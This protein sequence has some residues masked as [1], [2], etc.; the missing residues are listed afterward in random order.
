MKKTIT[1]NFKVLSTPALV[2]VLLLILSIFALKTFADK[3]SSLSN[4]L[5]TLS[6]TETS[7]NQKLSSLQSVST[8]A[9]LSEAVS[10]ALPGQNSGLLVV[11]QIRKVSS[12][13]GLVLGSI[14]SGQELQGQGG[15]SHVDMSVDVDGQFNQLVAFVSLLNGS[16]PISRISR[17][18]L[19]VTG[20]VIHTT[21]DLS[22]YW[23]ALPTTLPD[24]SASVSDLKDDEKTLLTKLTSLKQPLFVTV[25]PT[26]PTGRANPFSL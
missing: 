10:A 1:A 5:S 4:E 21:V 3:V 2:F 25:Q 19:S 12:D 15:V 6:Q 24:I 22:S 17:M 8:T 18:K 13:A 26:A 14:T 20:S 16:A 9:N 11:S 23:A 7:L